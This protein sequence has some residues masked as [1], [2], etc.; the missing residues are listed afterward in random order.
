MYFAHKASI[1]W[2]IVA[3]YFGQGWTALM[4]LIFLPVYIQYLGMAALD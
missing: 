2:N 4:G 1:Q 3:N